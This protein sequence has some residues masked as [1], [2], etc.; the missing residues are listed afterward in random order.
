MKK[1]FSLILA[2]L[3]CLSLCVPTFAAVDS[4]FGGEVFNLVTT[5]GTDAKTTR[6]FA[7]TAH[8]DH[9]P[10]AIRYAVAGTAWEN[11]TEAKAK[12]A[13]NTT[14]SGTSRAHYKVSL[15]DLLPG[16]TYEYRIGTPNNDT[17]SK[18]L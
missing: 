18:P 14:L 15:T 6:N 9:Y 17:W 7:W 1:L 3:L 13:G 4:D 8:S 2:T 16:T 12:L 11:F 5:F 10:M